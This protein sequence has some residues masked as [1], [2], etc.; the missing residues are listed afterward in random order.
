MFCPNT[1][2][3][4]IVFR[5]FHCC[6]RYE[7]KDAVLPGRVSFRPRHDSGCGVEGFWC[8][9]TK[10]QFI[11]SNDA[12]CDEN[13]AWT[14]LCE[15]LSGRHFERP[16]ESKYCEVERSVKGAFRCLGISVLDSSY[17]GIYS[18]VSVSGIRM[19]KRVEE[20][21]SCFIRKCA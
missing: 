5:L 11:G 14:I 2:F 13:A 7:F 1:D 17:D 10:W 12:V 16:G 15:D 9:A 19:W 18:G 4:Q 6:S 3:L 8:G 21:D 20:F